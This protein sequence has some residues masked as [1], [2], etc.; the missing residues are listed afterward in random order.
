MWTIIHRP[1]VHSPSS[2]F[3]LG[4]SSRT[5]IIEPMALAMTSHNKPCHA[6]PTTTRCAWPVV[7][8]SSNMLGF[9][10][11]WVADIAVRGSCHP[12]FPAGDR[13]APR[14]PDHAWPSAES[15][16]PS[17]PPQAIIQTQLRWYVHRAS[18]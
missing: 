7:A 16:P 18:R 6:A 11:T 3:N 2:M 14:E 9:M 5:A 17:P 8:D 13:S 1:Y 10:A 15:L 12:A 4:T